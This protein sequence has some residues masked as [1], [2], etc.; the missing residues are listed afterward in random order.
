M[1]QNAFS[2]T[3]KPCKFLKVVGAAHPFKYCSKE[4]PL[5]MFMFLWAKAVEFLK[6]NSYSTMCWALFNLSVTVYTPVIRMITNVGGA[7]YDA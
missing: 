3:L 6:G 7:N 2:G 4:D 5:S 1:Y